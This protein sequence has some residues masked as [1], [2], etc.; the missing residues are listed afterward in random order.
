MPFIAI[1]NR[2]VYAG[3][4]DPHFDGFS[5]WLIDESATRQE[6][7]YISAMSKK[8]APTFDDYERALHKVLD[9]NEAL[10]AELAEVKGRLD[11]LMTAF[12]ERGSLG[13]LQLIAHDKRLPPETRIRAAGLAVPFERPKLQVTA[14]ATVPLYDLLQERR[15]QGEI[16]EHDPKPAA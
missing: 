1:N 2:N 4:H 11:A 7:C 5:V 12:D 13:I 15:R 3:L 9:E 8:L 14:T 6:T 10:Q 16:I